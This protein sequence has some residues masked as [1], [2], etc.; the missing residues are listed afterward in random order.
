MAVSKRLRFEI[1][2]R[3]NHACRYCG[4]MA[5]DVALTIDHVTPIALGGSDD[6]TNLVTAC[7]D[8]NAGKSSTKPDAPL[9]EDVAQD[10]LRWAQAIQAVMDARS[11][12]QKP[13]DEYVNHFD[14]KWS[15]WHSGRAGEP[16]PRAENWRSSLERFYD[17]GVPMAEIERFIDV[18]CGNQRIRTSETW[19]Y[20]CGC[21]WRY[22]DDIRTAATAYLEKEDADGA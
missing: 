6:P 10:A 18:A 14:H 20:F 4:Q 21:V 17:L 5:P 13:R 16:I 7:K 3:D 12:A 11:E 19:R 22:V 9:L 2:R 8:C 1:M 15:E